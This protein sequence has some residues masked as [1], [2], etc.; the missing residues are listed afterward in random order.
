MRPIKP[1]LPLGGILFAGVVLYPFIPLAPR[2]PGPVDV[3]VYSK[4]SAKEIGKDLVGLGLLR[5]SFSFR[6]LTR[7]TG[8][9]R[10]LKAGLYRMQGRVSPWNAARILTEGK[11]ELLTLKVPEGY[12]VQQVAQ[13]LQRIEVVP[14]EGFLAACRDTA[15][16][17]SLD[18]P[19]PSAEGYLFPETYR[20]PLGAGPKALVELMARQFKAMVG[21]DFEDRCRARKLTPYQA[22]ILASIVEKEARR[23]EELSVIAGVMYNRLGKKMRLEVNATL[24]YVLNTRKAWLTNEQINTQSP[25]NTYRRRGL[26]PT[27]I[28]NPGLAA[29][30]AVL[31]PAETSY[32]YYVA[33]GDGSHLFAETFQEH[34]KNVKIAK[35]IRREKRLQG[36]TP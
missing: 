26:P 32:L 21:E 19:G 9:D 12:T 8:M 25:Y 17:K 13:E 14:M 2:V 3:P 35:R 7:M 20:V 1:L 6:L 23:K 34:Q 10:K 16:L 15:L 27:P 22:V 36:K 5:E 30:R 31:D 29:L 18:I 4:S 11:S 28:C 24:E 33:E